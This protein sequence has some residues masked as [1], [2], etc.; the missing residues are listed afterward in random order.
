MELKT[1]EK[2]LLV[3]KCFAQSDSLLST[4]ELAKKLD[5]NKATMS[6]VLSTLR[7][8]EFL[9]QDPGTRRYRLGP[10]M[11]HMARAFNRAMNGEVVAIAKPFADELR[12]EIGETS[13]IEVVYGNKIYLAY[14]AV[15]KNPISLT[16]D[17]GDQVMPNAH[18]GAKAIVAFSETDEIER[19][20]SKTHPA[21]TDNTITDPGELRKIYQKISQTG[22]AYDWEEYLKDI[23]AIGAP[24]F[25]H[26][27]HPV[28]AII[29]VVPSYRMEKKWDDRFIDELRKKANVISKRLHSSRSI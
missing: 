26:E 18:A 16:V 10:A 27:N 12:D 3:F 2:A 29:I 24:V 11:A 9:E 25:N 15:T 22:V 13:H 19:W 14:A 23:N 6:R 20:L 5:T 17:V 21:L 7:K 8:H 28:A 1:I 4:T